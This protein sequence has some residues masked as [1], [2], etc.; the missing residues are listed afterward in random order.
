ML[1]FKDLSPCG[2]DRVPQ[3]IRDQYFRNLYRG[4]GQERTLPLT[5]ER[6]EI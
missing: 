3:Q 2:A 4:V 6:T 1:E 5:M